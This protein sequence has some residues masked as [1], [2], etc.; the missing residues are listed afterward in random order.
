MSTRITVEVG[1][2]LLAQTAK[3]L[4]EQNR[5][6]RL[7]YESRLKEYNALRAASLK[8]AAEDTKA[9]KAPSGT[10]VPGTTASSPSVRNDVPEYYTPP[11]VAATGRQEKSWLLVPS[12]AGFNAI[13]RG[14]RPFAFAPVPSF[15]ASLRYML[16]APG[17]GPSGTNALY[18]STT[19]I[20]AFPEPFR[21]NAQLYALTGINAEPRGRSFTFEVIAM[22]PGNVDAPP[23]S[24]GR[25]I[26]P[27]SFMV[28]FCARGGIQI[29]AVRSDYG[30]SIATPYAPMNLIRFQY[31]TI[32]REAWSEAN[33]N[34]GADDIVS[35]SATASEVWHHLAMVQTPGSASSLRNISCYIDGTRYFNVADL[36][37]DAPGMP[38]WDP[39]L[40]TFDAGMRSDY[41]KSSA[42]N[43]AI[44]F[45]PTLTH[46]IRYTPRALYT[47]TSFTPPTSI[48]SLS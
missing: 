31:G 15:G 2:A 9:G 47:G 20:G 7:D 4:A 45:N 21:Y 43:G 36:A 17:E 22:L 32:M 25:Q 30:D 14:L 33:V 34:A 46:G 42:A 18:A 6:S 29:S 13:V 19:S 39:G 44:P 27:Y 24:D 38:A 37:I 8:A 41:G 3:A 26:R 10:A 23:G 35:S 5:Q 12:D 40:S 11:K 28:A 48:V 1:K 16:Y